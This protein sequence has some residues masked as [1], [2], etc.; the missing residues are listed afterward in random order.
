MYILGPEVEA[1]EAALSHYAH[2]PHVISC[3][4]GTDALGMALM[5]LNLKPKEVVF[6]PSFT[7]A[8]TA[9]VVAWM[10]ALP[11][12]VDSDPDTFNISIAS[13]EEAI[14]ECRQ[15]GARPVGMIPVDLFG[16][17]A[18]YSALQRIADREGLWILADAAQSFGAMSGHAPVGSLA[19]ISTTS[20]YPAK[21]LGCYG[22]GGAIFTH[23]EKI[24]EL[25][26]SIRV[27]GQGK[28]KYQNVRIGINGRLDTLQAAILL[29]KLAIFPQE[30]QARQRVAE[31]YDRAL[32][33]AVKTPHCAPGNTSV[34][35]Q[36]TVTLPEG[37]N[38]DA[39]RHYLKSQD[40]PTVVY[41]PIPLHQQRAYAHFPRARSLACCEML[42]H[43]VLSLPMHAYLTD[44]QIDCITSAVLCGLKQSIS[45]V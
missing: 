18:D 10:G 22:D 36:Y 25:L 32:N 23:D 41:Y 24:A 6:V 42:C 27:H 39:L 29:E 28:D 2:V 1:L 26:R 8:A 5:A 7:F 9:E 3:A 15:E 35:A 17:P 14:L 33:T 20:F 13:L 43:T 19:A 11:Y 21:P 31:H 4:N 34:W 44:A 16:Q 12:F 40:I 45:G 37:C 38:R 30:I